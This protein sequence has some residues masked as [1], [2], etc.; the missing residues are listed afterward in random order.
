M[1]AVYDGTVMQIPDFAISPPSEIPLPSTTT[2][3]FDGPTISVSRNDEFTSTVTLSMHGDADGDGAGNAGLG[4][5]ARPVGHATGRRRHDRADLVDR[6]CFSPA[7]NGTHG[8]PERHADAGRSHPGS[9]PSGSRESPATRTTRS[10]ACRSRSASRLTATTTVTTTT[11]S[12]SRRRGTSAWRTRSLDGSTASL[13]GTHHPSAA[14]VDRDQQR[15]L[16]QR[17]RRRDDRWRSAGTR[18]R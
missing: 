8:P 9:T 11:R 3:P 15:K 18:T 4:H 1:L 7:K 17:T 5:P 14:R 6:T 16:G 2:T 13:G 12:T 10:G